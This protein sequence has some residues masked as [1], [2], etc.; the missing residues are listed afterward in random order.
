MIGQYLIYHFN[1]LDNAKAGCPRN[2][3]ERKDVETLSEFKPAIEEALDQVFPG[4][5]YVLVKWNKKLFI[6]EK[7]LNN[8][9]TDYIRTEVKYHPLANQFTI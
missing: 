9:N 4:K 8:P 7:D 5:G 1:N 6:C 2:I 3:F